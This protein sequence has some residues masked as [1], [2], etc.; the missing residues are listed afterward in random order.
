MP[1][2]GHREN[3]SPQRYIKIDLVAYKP[4][5]IWDLCTNFTTVSDSKWGLGRPPPPLLAHIFFLLK[6]R[7]FRVKS[8]YFVVRTCDK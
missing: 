8:I 6:N 4:I 2:G 5:C 7:F 1:L 3:N